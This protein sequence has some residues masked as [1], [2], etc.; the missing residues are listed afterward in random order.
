MRILVVSEKF[1]KGGLETH[2]KT[3]YDALVE[4]NKF[5]FVFGKYES[6]LDLSKAKIYSGFNFSY[7]STVE[8]FCS[9]V[10]GLV[11]IIKTNKID[12]IIV[13][14]FYSI[15]PAVF[16][17]NLTKTKIILT[18]HGRTNLTFPTTP[19]EISLFEYFLYNQFNKVF[20]VSKSLIKALE[21]YKNLDAIYIPN[22]INFKNYKSHETKTNKK[23]AIISRLDNDK[24]NSVI[25]MLDYFNDVDVEEIDVIGDGENIN[26]IKEYIKEKNNSYKINLL[27]YI[28]DIPKQLDKGYTGVCGIGR[29][30]AESLAMNIPTVC[31]GYGKVV[32]VINK[33][34]YNLIKEENFIPEKLDNISKEDFKKQIDSINKGKNSKYCLRKEIIKDF[35]VLVWKDEF[36]SQINKCHE[37]NNFALNELYNEIMKFSNEGFYYSNNVFKLIYN[38]ISNYT[39]NIDLKNNTAMVYMMSEINDKIKLIEK[40]ISIIMSNNYQIDSS[41]IANNI[42]PENF[43]NTTDIYNQL[44][45]FGFKRMLKNDLRKIK[46]R[47]KKVIKNI[48]NKEKQEI[49]CIMCLYNEEA[50]IEDCINHLYNY[51]DKFVIF[52]DGSTDNTV[53]ILRKYDK[54]V[55]IIENKNKKYWAERKNRET[56]LKEA[57]NISETKMPWV[58]CIDA[59]ERFEIRF[60][61]NLRKIT[62]KYSGTKSVL[63]VYF[64]ELWG[65]YKKYRVDGLWGE[66]MKGLLFQ[67]DSKMTF[68]YESEHHIPWAY[69]EIINNQ[70]VLNYNL[71]HLKMINKK[72]RE[73]RKKLYKELDPNNKM[74][75][76]GYDY[77]TDAENIK[78][79]NINCINKYDYK[80][81]SEYYRKEEK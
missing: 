41:K 47:I 50:N 36:L 18:S 5:F 31:H 7:N 53:S 43:L 69:R 78:L 74:Q 51:V 64:R 9:D 48:K 70:I 6:K 27:G 71:Y 52:D 38:M 42:A 58:L 2:I 79:I 40:N 30:V 55:S 76:V 26:T 29:V 44:N 17:A 28:D 21:K 32:G 59:D 34:I 1:V 67:L 10:E 23:W 33:E 49:I 77:L 16:A 4:D 80:Y 72:D 8:E 54:V 14:P 20:S 65:S 3:L 39:Y 73:D 19:V 46:R 13:H 11:K 25:Q 24:I 61:K 60:L 81:L 62:N 63:N 56:V 68:D 75:P 22:L 45:T 37:I 35:D 12:V 15:Y 66:K 57:Y